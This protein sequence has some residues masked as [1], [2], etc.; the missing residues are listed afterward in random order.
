[1]VIGMSY[2][3]LTVCVCGV[4]A[5]EWFTAMAH[6]FD[7]LPCRLCVLK[8]FGTSAQI[9]TSLAIHKPPKNQIAAK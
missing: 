9:D 3:M 4:R 6:A 1:M 8:L 7:E 2:G 5:N